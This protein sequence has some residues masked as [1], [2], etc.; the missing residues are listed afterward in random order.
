MTLRSLLGK[1]LRRSPCATPTLALD[2]SFSQ[3]KTLR[4][5]QHDQ[6]PLDSPTAR[7]TSASTRSLFDVRPQTASLSSPPSPAFKPLACS[8]T[9]RALATG[10]AGELP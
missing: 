3:D 6:F 4:S 7:R 8:N 2:L 1:R 9:S 5:Q 10:P